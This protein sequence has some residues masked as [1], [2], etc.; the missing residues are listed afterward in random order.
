[1]K[2]LVEDAKYMSMSC[3]QI[4]DYAFETHYDCYRNPG[5]GSKDVCDIWYSKSGAGLLST[6][7][8]KEYFKK[9]FWSGVCTLKLQSLAS[10]AS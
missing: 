8:L 7:E 10:L 3:A 1:M 2:K 5:F 4:Q 6:Y 9:E